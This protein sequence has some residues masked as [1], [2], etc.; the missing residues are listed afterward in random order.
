VPGASREV[1]VGGLEAPR[2]DYRVGAIEDGALDG[3][4]MRQLRSWLD[5]AIAAALPEPTAVTLATVGEDGLPD[6]RVVLLR[7]VDERG[8]WWFTNRR[9]V[10]GR[11]LA[12]TPAASIVAHWHPLERQVRV[13]GRVE[14]LPDE[15]SDAYFASRPRESQ[16]GAWA[17]AQSEP[18]ADRAALDA[19]VAEVTARFAGGPIPRPPHWGGYLLRPE[20]VEFWQG[21]PGRLHDRLL[22][23][24]AADGWRVVRLQP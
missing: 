6:A 11:Q 8:V 5:D 20:A 12:A 2:E 17:S 16:L 13:R 18:I 9:S 22:H 24:R 19:Q 1:T 7:G 10:K 21:R 14:P 15:E 3:D 23:R 4:P